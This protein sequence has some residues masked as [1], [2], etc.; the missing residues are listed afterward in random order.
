VALTRGS[1]ARE[2]EAEAPSTLW[3]F[4]R[5]GFSLTGGGNAGAV[6]RDEER[7]TELVA[8]SQTAIQRLRS[9]PDTTKIAPLLAD[10][11]RVRDESLDELHELYESSRD[12]R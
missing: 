9:F 10:M 7:L 1:P 12:R 8:A 2:G 6:D 3:L 5:C 4:A 11:E